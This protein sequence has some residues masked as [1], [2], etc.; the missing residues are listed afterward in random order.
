[1]ATFTEQLVRERAR[2]QTTFRS[3]DAL[4]KESS[5]R[6]PPSQNYDIFLSHSV[7]DAEIVLGLKLMLEDLGRSVYVD[8]I[9]DYQLD[10][11]RVTPAT[12]DRLRQ[13][14]R[15]CRS[16]MYLY[17]QNSPSSKWMPWE[18]GFSDGHHGAVAIVP[19]TVQPQQNF[20]GQ[21]YLGI[22]PWVGVA[23]PL[24]GIPELRIQKNQFDYRSWQTWKVAPRDFRVTA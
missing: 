10:R 22:Y 23:I 17:T 18:L 15:Q 21:E 19:V 20:Q 5:V 13:R 2:R 12:A 1:M 4:L 8:W 24:A 14:M 3:A 7:L 16:L 9:D 11:S 6:S